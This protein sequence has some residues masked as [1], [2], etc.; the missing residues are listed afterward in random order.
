MA[1][2]SQMEQHLQNSV[3]GTPKINPDEQ[4]H[5]LGTFRERVSLAMTIA[6]VTD[7]KSLDAFIT[8]ITAHP[9]YQ[10]ILN[11]HIDQADLAPYLKLASQHNLKFT[12]RQ[13]TIYGVNDSD[14]GLIVASDTAINQNPISLSKKY[15]EKPA[16]KPTAPKKSWFDKL[17]GH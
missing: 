13:D 11:G 12:I 1:E 9:D 4:R 5:Y 6:E 7:R 2:K 17:I 16:E 8:E 10:V 3:Y 15:P 14:L